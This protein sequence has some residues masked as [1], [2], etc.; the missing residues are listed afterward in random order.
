MFHSSFYVSS[1]QNFQQISSFCYC[2]FRSCYK[3]W[4]LT[5][6][7]H[8][9]RPYTENLNAKL[10]AL[11]ED[12]VFPNYKLYMLSLWHEWSNFCE[13]ESDVTIKWYVNA[14]DTHFILTIR[15]VGRCSTILSVGRR[16]NPIVV[17]IRSRSY[18]KISLGK[19]ATRFDNIRRSN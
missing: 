13:F 18:V 4:I 1:L 10:T 19:C 2:S 3:L 5:K 17:Q 15:A 9:S 6:A 16:P 8:L 12:V 14:S 7:M 11:L